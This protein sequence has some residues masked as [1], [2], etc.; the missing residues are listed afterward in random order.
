MSAPLKVMLR[1]SWV[2]VVLAALAGVGVWVA[3]WPVSP[4]VRAVPLAVPAGDQ[5]L[6]WVYAAT[7]AAAWQRLVAATAAAAVRLEADRPGFGLRVDDRNAFPP[8]TTAVPEV[9]LSVAG[10]PGRLRL[11]WY[12]LTSDQKTPD[13]VDAL[14]RRPTPPL[15]VLGGSSSDV[16]IELA[17]ELSRW[18]AAGPAN[19]PAT[20]APVLLLTQATVDEVKLPAGTAIPLN[21]VHRD[22]TFR[23][24]FTNRQ[25]ARAA[26]SFIWT[27]DDLRPDADPA[28]MAIWED[29]PYSMD[30]ADRFYEALRLPAAWAVVREWA[31]L[32]GFSAA[33]GFPFSGD[34]MAAGT[35]RLA[36]TP[37]P[38][39]IP[40]SEGGFS[41]PN[42]WE[43]DAARDVTDQLRQ[44]P[45]QRRP[46]LI[47]PAA[48]QPARRFLLGV[49]RADPVLAGRFVVATGDSLAFNTI[50][51]DRN[52]AWPV[53]DLPYPLVC[54]CHRN[55][56][57]R[58]AGFRPHG[59]EDPAADYTQ[60]SPATGT[61]DLLLYVDCIAALV[62]GAYRP[63]GLVADPA[64]LAARLRRLVVNRVGHV[65]LSDGEPPAPSSLPLF[66]EYGQRRTGTGEH[67]VC[68][69]PAVSDGRVL[70]RSTISVW[71]ARQHGGQ[72]RRWEPTCPDLTVE[73]DETPG[74]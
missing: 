52:L 19:P 9:V 8:Q 4:A 21:L 73:Y 20:A 14:A 2:S 35:F 39:R 38:A 42:R 56:V 7:S 18:G 62:Q 61:E 68:L 58:E 47:V 41:R 34:S 25:M 54:F 37:L 43:T 63:T 13:W 70:P 26:T 12:K 51:R 3:V 17:Q 24:C 10:R 45:G 53:Q 16:G 57:D 72:G 33:G 32:G 48:S 44:R 6:A 67:I 31:W 59:E 40:F 69:R 5:E 15:A 27:Q 30:L 65:I 66:D 49:E 23:A 22:R 46:L 60:G 1:P 71:A 64:A 74:P 50:Y 29:D 28:Y 55:P 11:R 36:L